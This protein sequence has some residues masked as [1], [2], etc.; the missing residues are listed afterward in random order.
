MPITTNGIV[1]P[2][3]GDEPN[4]P[5]D[6]LAMGNSIHDK[7]TAAIGALKPNAEPFSGQGCLVGSLA[8]SDL[9]NV[10]CFYYNYSPGTDAN[11]YTN[12][13]LPFTKALITAQV[14]PTNGAGAPLGI[15][16]A[17]SLPGT[18]VSN[19]RLFVYAPS[20]TAGQPTTYVPLSVLAYGV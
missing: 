3:T 5:A 14:T 4:V 12:L 13:Y 1:T 7:I 8:P 11:G 19:L 17:I 10:R 15:S 9:P 6:M 18:T 2:T 16:V 20:G